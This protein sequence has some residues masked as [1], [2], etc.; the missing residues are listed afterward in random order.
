MN[1]GGFVSYHTKNKQRWSLVA[2]IFT[3]FNFVPGRGGGT[4][5]SFEKVALVYE[6]TLI[7]KLQKI[8]NTALL[9][10]EILSRIVFGSII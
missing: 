7:Q 5:R 10:Q 4:T 6:G 2:R 9:S 1:L 3:S 8:M